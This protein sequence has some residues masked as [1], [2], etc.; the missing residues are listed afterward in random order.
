MPRLGLGLA[1]IVL[2]SGCN[3]VTTP[4]PLFPTDRGV[5]K[6]GVWRAD[7]QKDCTFDDRAPIS[8]WP[9]CAAAPVIH[10]NGAGRVSGPDEGAASFDL[11]VVR[12]DPLLV[13][14]TAIR[15]KGDES[16][17]QSLTL[18]LAGRATTL[19][20]KGRATAVELWLVQCGPPGEGA[21]LTQRPLPGLVLDQQAKSCTTD[22]P[23]V[24]RDAG[25][26]SEAW[27]DPDGPLRLRWLRDGG[28]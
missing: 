2:I 25:R 14:A 10:A 28:T 20:A 6:P 9:S 8:Q 7:M 11:R 17:S 23:E 26:A 12:G 21:A 19:D 24:L 4:A 22:Q 3:A 1:A 5:L 16:G 15:A 13:Q 18:Y 27:T